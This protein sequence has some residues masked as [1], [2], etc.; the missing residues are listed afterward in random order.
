MREHVRISLEVGAA[1]EVDVW[2]LPPEGWAR[3]VARGVPGLAVGRV[4]LADGTV[5]PGFLAAAPEYAGAA[6]IPRIL[7]L[8]AERH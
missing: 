1:V 8:R 7:L 2:A 6:S 3:F 4:E 5:V